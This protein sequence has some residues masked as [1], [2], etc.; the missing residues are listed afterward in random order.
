[1]LQAYATGLA[2]TTGQAVSF[3]NVE[4]IGTT[5]TA[6]IGSTTVQLNA[7]GV[8]MVSFNA[9]GTTTDAGTFGFQMHRDGNAVP[10]AQAATNTTTTAG[11]N[12]AVSFQ[13]LMSVNRCCQ[14]ANGVVLSFIYTGDAGTIAL[15]NV[16]VTKVR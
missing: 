16:V 12:A 13:T 15:A 6:A 7:P 3:P 8:Y 10:Q 2:A 1:M 11:E 9:T 4:R 5:V 14:S